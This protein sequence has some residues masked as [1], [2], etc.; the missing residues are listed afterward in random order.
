MVF[1]GFDILRKKEVILKVLKHSNFEKINREILTLRAI[2]TQSPH[3]AK[4]INFGVDEMDGAV[5]LVAP[6]PQGSRA[7]RETRA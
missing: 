4:L 1:D 2:G 7:Y 6:L 3:L 5:I